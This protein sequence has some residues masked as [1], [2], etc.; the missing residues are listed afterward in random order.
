MKKIALISTFCD[1]EEKSIVLNENLKIL[2]SLDIDTF[3][4]SPIKID[5]DCDFLFITKENPILSWPERS[6]AMWKTVNY[7]EKLL[8]LTYF[9]NDYGWA[10]LYQIK[11]VMEFASTYDYDIFYFLIYDLKIDEKIIDDINKNIVNMI[12]PRKDFDSNKIY[13]SSLHFAIFNK[14]KLK[15]ISSLIDK[16]T[17]Q[18]KDL[19]AEDYIH[20][21]VESM[22]MNHSN[23]SVTDLINIS[24]TKDLFNHSLSEKYGLFF[25]KDYELKFK[26]FLFGLSQT[27]TIY[28]NEETYQ[29]ENEKYLLETEFNFNEIK[30]LKVQYENETIDYLNK[31]NGIVKSLIHFL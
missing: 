15:I 1:T 2:K 26:I 4:I 19:V 24:N 13:P 29:V 23:H 30:S 10:S 18:K 6:M 5:V 16:K 22:G 17:Y 27:T 21:W 3:V 28:V 9:I 31:Y 25:C 20:Q 14:E 12:Y 8:K 11:K 7:D